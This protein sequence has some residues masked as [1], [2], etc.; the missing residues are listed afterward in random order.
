MKFCRYNIDNVPPSFWEEPSSRDR[1]L[2]TKEAA[3]RLQMTPRQLEALRVQSVQLNVPVPRFQRSQSTREHWHWDSEKLEEW[4]SQVCE[5][6]SKEEQW[7]LTSANDQTGQAPGKSDGRT[8]AKRSK[9]S[10]HHPKRS[11]SS[12]SRNAKKRSTPMADGVDLVQ[13]SK[14]LTSKS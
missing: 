6:N 3:E 13:F 5:A 1:W 2:S 8:K 10:P 7:K 9:P 11:A 4:V 12:G 14:S